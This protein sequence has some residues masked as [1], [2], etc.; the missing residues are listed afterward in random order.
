MTKPIDFIGN[1][2]VEETIFISLKTVNT[3]LTVYCKA[4][5]KKSEDPKWLQFCKDHRLTKRETTNPKWYDL[6]LQ[7]CA[8][9]II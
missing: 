7:L 5:Y 6:Y 1:E 4:T 8:E 9:G 2:I 3:S